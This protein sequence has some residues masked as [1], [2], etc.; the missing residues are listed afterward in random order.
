[1][2]CPPAVVDAAHILQH[3]DDTQI[4]EGAENEVRAPGSRAVHLRVLPG[5]A[6][7]TSAA[8]PLPMLAAA[9]R[10]AC[11]DAVSNL[12]RWRRLWSRLPLPTAFC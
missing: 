11:T 8:L 3:L 2:H 1:M 10:P 7:C 5:I 6:L 12:P 4:E 9:H